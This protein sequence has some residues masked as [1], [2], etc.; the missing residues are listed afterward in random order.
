MGEDL[1][2]K[3]AQP[4]FLCMVCWRALAA[5]CDNYRVSGN[6]ASATNPMLQPAKRIR[7]DEY[8]C[9]ALDCKL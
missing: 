3:G 2:R 8:E 9:Q 4:S 5:D 1:C 7:H 6:Q